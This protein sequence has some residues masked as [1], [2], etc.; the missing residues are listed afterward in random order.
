[1]DNVD[2]TLLALAIARLPR[3]RGRPLA[4][5]A[6]AI[7]A[8]LPDVDVVFRLVDGIPG[9][10]E[11][12][13]GITH[14]LLGIAVQALLLGALLGRIG[15]LR[16][17]AAPY[18][19]ALVGLLSHLALDAL[20]SYGVR[21]FLPF[22]ERRFCSDLAFEA[23][24]WLALSFAAVIRWPRPAVL[25]APLAYLALL[26]GLHASARAAADRRL[27]EIAGSP[28]V[29]S[30]LVPDFGVPWRFTLLIETAGDVAWVPFD[31]FGR[32]G[33]PE[34]RPKDLDD[35]R[36]AAALATR[37][38]AIWRGFARF[39]YAVVGS[40]GRV[41]LRDARYFYS[42]WCDVVI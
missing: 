39:P 42:S 22:S 27:P 17:G 40:D 41:T 8:N 3:F 38:G 24:P 34:R 30:A 14:S 36:V 2:H 16:W 12:H 15:R 35:P 28:V 6:L 33:E 21:P 25:A 18:L 5:P 7:G 23:D 13:R 29:Q 10:L 32:E 1:M 20:S 11:H 37:E 4:M 9:Y 19:A 31:A 26:G